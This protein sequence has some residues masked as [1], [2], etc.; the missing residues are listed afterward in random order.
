MVIYTTHIHTHKVYLEQINLAQSGIITVNPLLLIALC[1]QF[2]VERGM[3]VRCE[4]QCVSDLGLLLL[5][6]LVFNV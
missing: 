6:Q 5:L 2:C 1:L 3:H 4:Y